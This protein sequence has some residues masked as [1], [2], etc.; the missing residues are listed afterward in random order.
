MSALDK[1]RSVR[2]AT[3]GHDLILDGIEGFAVTVALGREL[4][5]DINAISV[6]GEAF[7]KE[8]DE[9]RDDDDFAK[10]FNSKKIKV[11]GHLIVVVKT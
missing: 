6:F 1:I 5:R 7:A 3:G 11:F 4:M 2:R 10:K 8:I 9:L